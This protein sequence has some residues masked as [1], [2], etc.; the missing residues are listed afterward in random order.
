MAVIIRVGWLFTRKS[1]DMDSL[2]HSILA[3]LRRHE[4]EGA[5]W[6][7]HIADAMRR[8]TYSVRARLH[9]LERRGLA[10]RVVIGNPTSWMITE[11]GKAS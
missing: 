1:P 6:T 7:G 3:Y 2:A 8:P 4:V 10:R 5:L 11:T 9:Q